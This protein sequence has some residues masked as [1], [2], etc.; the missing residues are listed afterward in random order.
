M[1]EG[2]GVYRFLAL[3][4]I[5]HA[6]G[7]VLASNNALQITDSYHIS[8]VSNDPRWGEFLRKKMGFE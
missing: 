3:T 8:R 2:E 5:E 7:N 1:R 6:R 4:A